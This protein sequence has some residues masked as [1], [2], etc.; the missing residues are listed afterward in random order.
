[1][2]SAHK[3]IAEI[4]GDTMNQHTTFNE[5]SKEVPIVKETDVIVCGGGPAGVAAALAAARTGARTQLI[6]V[7]G[8]LGGVWTAGLLTWIIDT[9]DKPGILI[10]IMQRLEKLGAGLTRD[11]TKRLLNPKPNF[12]FAYDVEKMK[13]LLEEM[14]QEAGID[15]RYHTRIAAA[16]VDEENN[17][18]TI[19]T[20]SKSG[21]EAW[22][23]KAFVDCTGD[24]DLAA[25]AGC[26]FDYGNPDNGQAQPMSLLA[27]IGGV[28]AEEIGAFHRFHPK[29]TPTNG[30]PK[31]LL[32]DEIERAGISTSY[33]NPSLFKITD[34][35][36][37]LMAHHEYGV[38]AMNA[39]D[40]TRAT[41][42]GR[43]ELNNIITG[44]KSL[45]GV[46]KNIHLVSTAEQIGTREGRRIHGLYTVSLEDVISGARHHDAVCRSSFS[47]DIHSTD[48]KQSTAIAKHDYKTIPYDI[49]LRAL[50]AKD[51]NR[52]LMAGRCISGSF[53]AHASYRVTG[54]AV[55][56]GQGAGVAAALSAKHQMLPQNLPWSLMEE[57]Q[58]K[59]S[60]A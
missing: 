45:G 29:G 57:A 4:Q 41:I 56:L 60:S 19:F 6:E 55:A 43:R 46:W 48:P 23:A 30:D 40:V 8:C 37:T 9:Y 36:F 2:L 27:V 32:F 39:D 31:R 44:L 52:L 47:V 25:L 14:C 1:M 15:V 35:L 7:H 54:N 49:P 59:L 18:S 10:D 16:F 17:L 28:D 3:Y 24:G 5:P 13:F 51:V 21:R 26:R 34:N 22:K 58:A 50:I 53:H 12:A 20:E 42:H 33:S 38:C 11:N